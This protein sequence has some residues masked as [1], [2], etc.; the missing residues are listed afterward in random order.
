MT[1]PKH[2]R[3]AANTSPARPTPELRPGTARNGTASLRPAFS[4]IA[5]SFA[6]AMMVATSVP[7]LA[8]TATDSEARASVYAPVED[9][10]DYAPQTVEVGSDGVMSQ[11]AAE[12]YDVEA[13]PPPITS[14]VASV[15]NVQLIDTNAIVWP[16]QNP[17]KRS[18]GFGPRSA[19]CS[20]CSS[21]HDGVDFNPGN[22]TPVVSIADGVV[23]LATENGGGLGVNV[24]VQHNIGGEL[25]TSS[26]AHMQYGSIAVSVGQQVTA[27]QQL[28]LV[29]TTG[30]S[31]GPHLHLEM[32]GADGVR[33]DGFAWLSARVG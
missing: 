1:P 17:T 4:I 12:Q 7:A 30:Q 8:V 29:G 33:F 19:P 2:G 5:M 24:E 6:A 13:A 32:F 23:V 14:Q 18:D 3:R 15:G 25:I 28:G 27:G 26:Y 22:G 9:T 31:T 16:V 20:G 11:L 10:I 21:S